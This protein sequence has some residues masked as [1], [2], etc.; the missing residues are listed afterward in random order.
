MSVSQQKDPKELDPK[1][2]FYEGLAP[3]LDKLRKIYKKSEVEEKICSILEAKKNPNTK[4]QNTYYLLSK[5]KVI[6]V[7]GINCLIKLEE[8]ENAITYVCPYEDL[9]DE[10]HQTH[11]KG[12][13]GGA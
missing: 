8:S 13:H 9:Y 4:F 6:E 5:Y 3:L 7:G 11:L 10:I 1:T 12:G 2:S